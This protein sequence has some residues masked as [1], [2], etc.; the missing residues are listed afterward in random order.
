[1]GLLQNAYGRRFAP[2]VVLSIEMLDLLLR[3]IARRGRR[4]YRC[5][6]CRRCGRIG[7]RISRCCCRIGRCGRVGRRG[8]GGCS[9]IRCR[10]GCYG[11]ISRR[12]R[13]GGRCRVPGR[14]KIVTACCK[15]EHDHQT[16]NS[17]HSF[18]PIPLKP[19]RIARAEESLAGPRSG[20]KR[21][22]SG[23]KRRVFCV[24]LWRRR[25]AF[26]S[27]RRPRLRM[28]WT[29]PT[30]ACLRAPGPWAS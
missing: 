5:V 13:I 30:S 25:E 14:V 27:S 8:I 6:R 24:F 16:Y 23:A 9:R 11:R 7:S 19:V 1:M 12:C 3:R 15:R 17:I 21:G 2:A 20:N 4:R 18:P 28:R 29:A 22:G 10:I 26:P